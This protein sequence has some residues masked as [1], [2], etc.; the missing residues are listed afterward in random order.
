MD[1]LLEIVMAVVVISVLG[2]GLLY[3]VNS[4]SD[5]FLGFMDSQSHDA[6]CDLLK[7]QHS[8][9]DSSEEMMSIEDKARSNDCDWVGG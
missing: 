4:Q 5:S 7:K 1:K 6:Q 9:A 8:N 2:L 3:A